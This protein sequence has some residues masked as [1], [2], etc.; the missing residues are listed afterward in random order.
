MKMEQK[1]CS[2]LTRG[3]KRLCFDCNGQKQMCILAP[4]ELQHELI[5]L[6]EEGMT[7][8]I[9]DMKCGKGLYTAELLLHLREKYPQIEVECVIPFEEY[10]GRWAEPYRDRYFDIV[11]HCDK[12]TLLQTRYTPDCM[13]KQRQYMVEAAD[14]VIVLWTPNH[15]LRK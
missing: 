9:C 7:Y 6:I 13:L 3:G 11:A 8:F 4:R 1:K 12:E 15:T 2:I 5:R 10:A 14:C